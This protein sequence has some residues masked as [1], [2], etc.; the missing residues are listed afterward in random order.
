MVFRRPLLFDGVLVRLGASRRTFD[1]E[2][3][4]VLWTTRPGPLANWFDG[5]GFDGPPNTTNSEPVV[6]VTTAAADRI[7]LRFNV[8]IMALPFKKTND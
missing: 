8:S 1:V 6:R 7:V 4:G 2:A 3:S 5:A